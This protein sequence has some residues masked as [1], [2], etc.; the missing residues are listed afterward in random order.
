M[1]QM[2][3]QKMSSQERIKQNILELSQQIQSLDTEIEK[4]E[5]QLKKEGL[6]EVE[7]KT[8]EED[9]QT[10]V[11]DR[12]DASLDIAMLEEILR[13]TELEEVYFRYDEEGSGCG[14]DWNESG[15]YD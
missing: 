14:V 10:L 6:S 15:Y 4:V 3:E 2:E 8:L 12:V 1:R 13:K 7:K 11:L 5:A 9:L